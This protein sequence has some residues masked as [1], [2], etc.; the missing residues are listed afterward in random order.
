M[1]K[2]R[3]DTHQPAAPAD[4]G[5]VQ[6]LVEDDVDRKRVLKAMGSAGAASFG[7]FALASCG[8]SKKGSGGTSAATS[9]SAAASAASADIAILDDRPLTKSEVLAEAGP[10]IKK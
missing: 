5:I 6:R 7:A 3:Q 1:N 2:I 10:L 9:G 4:T 8:S